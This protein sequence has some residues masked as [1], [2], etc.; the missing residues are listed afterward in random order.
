MEIPVLKKGRYLSL[1]IDD[2]MK[3]LHGIA[4]PFRELLAQ[5]GLAPQG[6]CVEWYLSQK[7]VQCMIWLED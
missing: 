4:N 1:T 6:Y 5:P 2:Y 7:E 3:D